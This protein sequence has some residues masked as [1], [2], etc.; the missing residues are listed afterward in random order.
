MLPLLGTACPNI[1]LPLSLCKPAILDGITSYYCI[2]FTS[3]KNI[4][5]GKQIGNRRKLTA[6]KPYGTK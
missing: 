4:Y 2:K 6:S 1:T 3:T 5:Y